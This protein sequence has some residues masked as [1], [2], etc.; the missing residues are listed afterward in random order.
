[1][2]YDADVRYGGHKLLV[3]VAGVGEHSADQLNAAMRG[4]HQPA[5]G[6]C[7]NQASVTM[8]DRDPSPDATATHTHHQFTPWSPA[9]LP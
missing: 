2:P 5:H 1:V 6:G 9:E 7:R 4:E 3:T 8:R